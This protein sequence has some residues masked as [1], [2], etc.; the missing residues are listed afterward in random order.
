[1]GCGESVHSLR[2]ETEIMVGKRVMS[3]TGVTAATAVPVPSTTLIRIDP[4]NANVPAGHIGIQMKAM[5]ALIGIEERLAQLNVG[6][7]P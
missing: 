2:V 6:K 3:T 5:E 7:A 1:M 4:G